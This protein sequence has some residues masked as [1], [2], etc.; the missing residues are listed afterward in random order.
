[1]TC[2]M[3]SSLLPGWTGTCCLPACPW[4][5]VDSFSVHS[6][7]SPESAT[8]RKTKKYSVRIPECHYICLFTAC[9]STYTLLLP[10]LCFRSCFSPKC[11]KPD[12]IFYLILSTQLFCVHLSYC[13][14]ACFGF[15]SR[16]FA[17]DGTWILLF[18][19]CC[20]K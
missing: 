5:A 13:F 15:F 2:S 19:R 9:L 10:I 11:I 14:S 4:T 3:D 20:H 18:C 1:M 16:K 17:S 12:S 6:F 8:K 7:G